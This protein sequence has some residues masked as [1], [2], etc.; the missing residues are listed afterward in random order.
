MAALGA[1]LGQ[2]QAG[3]REPSL[4]GPGPQAAV[5]AQ[6]LAVE[7]GGG[8]PSAPYTGASKPAPVPSSDNNNGK[9]SKRQAVFGV[10]TAIDL[11]KFVAAREQDQ[12]TKSGSVLD[13]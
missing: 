13:P 2:A 8:T 10:V 5:W 11:L 7:V 3:T 4:P 1:T 9:S 6:P 12:K